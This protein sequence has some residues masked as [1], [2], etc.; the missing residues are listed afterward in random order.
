VLDE[1]PVVS[2][3]GN[4]VVPMVRPTETVMVFFPCSAVPRQ[5]AVRRDDDDAGGVEEHA[6]GAGEIEGKDRGP[7][8]AD[9]APMVPLHSGSTAPRTGSKWDTS[10]AEH[11]ACRR[12]TTDRPAERAMLRSAEDARRKGHADKVLAHLGD[13]QAGS[14]P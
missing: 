4:A 3:G 13:R 6:V 11:T 1:A 10:P 5:P 8:L 12:E 7:G 2:K 14:S 9:D